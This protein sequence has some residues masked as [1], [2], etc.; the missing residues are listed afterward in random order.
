MAE[1]VPVADASYAQA[2][3]DIDQLGVT[4][5]HDPVTPTPLVTATRPSYRHS[6]QGGFVIIASLILSVLLALIFLTAG[7]PKVT[8]AKSAQPMRDK[9]Q[10]SSRLWAT[11]GGLE[12]LAAIG[13]VAGLFFPLLGVAAAAGLCI[14]MAGAVVTHLRV[15]DNRG[16]LP[17]AVLLVVCIATVA[18]KILILKDHIA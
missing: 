4:R 1:F 18:I 7:S 17:A 11:V 12:G 9:L 10:L 2:L 13:L 16:A 14:L 15:G 5:N 8:N 6:G 3:T